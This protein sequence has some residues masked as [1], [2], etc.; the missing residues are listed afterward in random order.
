MWKLSAFYFL[1]SCHSLRFSRTGEISVPDFSI[2]ENAGVAGI[3]GG[4]SYQ[5]WQPEEVFQHTSHNFWEKAY[6]F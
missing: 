6:S 5:P 1:V 4:V 2:A 3:S